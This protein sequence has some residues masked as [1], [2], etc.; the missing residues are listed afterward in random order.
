MF[1]AKYHEWLRGNPM[2]L[3]K[4]SSRSRV[5]V[6]APFNRDMGFSNKYNKIYE[7]VKKHHKEGPTR[8]YL[9]SGG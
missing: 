4:F 3:L 6:A 7:E 1:M 2:S 9:N 8:S 5:S